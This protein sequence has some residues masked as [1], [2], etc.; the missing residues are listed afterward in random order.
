MPK[1]RGASQ[2]VLLPRGE[3]ELIDDSYNAGPA[4]VRAALAVLA[5]KKPG[6]TG[7]RIAVLGDMLEL[8]RS[9]EM[10]HAALARDLKSADVDLVFMA[11]KE[12]ASLDAT[13]PPSMRGGYASTSDELCSLV[14]AAL[15]EG[16]VVLVKGSLGIRMG[17]IA[18]AISMIRPTRSPPRTAVCL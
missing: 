8:G 3:I 5:N 7:R 9:S 2:R 12:M 17:Q 11:G 15:R 4:S 1:G 13:L 18:E 10:M 14:L 6:R 16:D